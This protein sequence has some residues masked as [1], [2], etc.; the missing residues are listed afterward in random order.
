MAKSSVVERELKFDVGPG[1]VIPPVDQV[2]PEGGR[3]E[4]GS[5]QLRSD[6]FDTADH[7]LLRGGITLRRRTGTSDN[8]WQLKVPNRPFGEEIQAPLEQS[9][10]G[11]AEGVPDDLAT[12]LLGTVGDQALVQVASI[13]TDRTFTRLVDADG[14]LLAEIGDDQVRASASGET[15]TAT[16][17]REVEIE[18][19]AGSGAL[20]LLDALDRLL[21]HAGAQPSDTASKLARALSPPHSIP[22][23]RTAKQ[24]AGDLVARYVAEQQGALLAGDLGLRRGDETVIHPTRVATRRLRSTLRIFRRFVDSD[25][26]ARLDGELR[27]Y[28]GLLGQVRD[29][30]VLRRRL[31]AMVDDLDDSLLLGPV[32]ARIDT[33]LQTEQAEHWRRLQTEISSRRYLALLADLADWVDHPPHTPAADQSARAVLKPVARSRRRVKQR[34]RDANIAGDIDLLHPARKAA[35]RA[36]YAAE[37]AEPVT[38]RKASR[39]QAKRYQRLQDLLGEHQDS[40]VSATLLRRLGAKAG[41]TKGENGFSFGILFEREQRNARVAQNKARRAASKSA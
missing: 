41:T 10:E 18:L 2:L 26:A 3:F 7:A 25:R 37:A 34:L 16:R 40:L 28:A 13:V 39:R 1:F 14:A 6:Y 32:K 23:P 9:S 17:W 5:Q 30:Q 31:D 19:G 29:R 27:W 33:E 8:G 4:H 22:P 24:T 11:G 12:L 35:K 15:A 38:G 20:Q 36:R 21:R